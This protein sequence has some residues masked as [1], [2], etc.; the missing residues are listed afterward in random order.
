MYSRPH[1]IP[2][3]SAQYPSY[4]SAQKYKHLLPSNLSSKNAPIPLPNLLPELDERN[5]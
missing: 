3:L 2:K 4:S 5:N 1:D